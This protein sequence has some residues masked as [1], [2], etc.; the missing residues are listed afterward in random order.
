M[1][2]NG[3][4]SEALTACAELCDFIEWAAEALQMRREKHF[5]FPFTKYMDSYHQNCLTACELVPSSMA[6]GNP[7]FDM[8]SYSSCFLQV[9]L[10][11]EVLFTYS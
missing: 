4:G 6:L 5:L 2:K 10:K 7:A 3:F 1:F 9:F 11:V 8:C